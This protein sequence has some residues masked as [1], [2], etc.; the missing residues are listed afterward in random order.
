MA[1]TNKIQKV[2]IYDIEIEMENIFRE[3]EVN[4]TIEAMLKP[5]V[6]LLILR[7]K[8]RANDKDK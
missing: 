8:E 4:D 5:M 7:L 6:E 1:G 2:R 3:C